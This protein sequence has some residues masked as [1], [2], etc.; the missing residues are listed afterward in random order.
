MNSGFLSRTA[1]LFL[2]FVFFAGADPAA[3]DS[4]N[5]RI[6]RLS[7]VQGDV[8]FSRATSG[9]P[10]ADQN[11]AWETAELNLPIRQ[12]YVLATGN[13]RAEVEFENGSMAFLNESTVLEFYDLTLENGGRNTRLVLRQGTASFHVNPGNEDYFSVTGGDFTAVAGP[14]SSFRMDNSDG[15]STVD[16]TKGRINVIHGKTTTPLVKGQSLSMQAGNDAID[17]GRLPSDDDFDHWVSGRVDSVV[18]ATNAALQYTSSPYYTSGFAD[19]YTYGSWYPISG[20]GNC[21]R[22]YGAGFG[23]SPFDSGGWF[24]DP[25]YGT[26]FIGSQP[27]GWL[28]YHF[29]GWIFDPLYGW[30]W[31]PG[32]FGYG[33]FVNWSPVTAR[34]VRSKTGLLGVVP[35]HPLDTKSKAPVNLAQGVMPI[36]GGVTSARVPVQVADGWKV[37]KNPPR[38]AFGNEPVRVGAPPLRT[39]RTFVATNTSERAGAVSTGSSSTIAYDPREHRFVNSNPAPTELAKES[40]ARNENSQPGKDIAKEHGVNPEQ[41]GTA[42]VATVHAGTTPPPASTTARASV[43]PTRVVTPPPA[44]RTSSGA[45]AENSGGESSRGASTSHASSAPASHPS[46]GGGRPH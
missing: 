13:G 17:V 8:R 38:E 30:L 35:V 3:A 19:L 46:S 4:S 25:F 5:A 29:G 31:A 6:I 45:R 24:S 42:T 26:G 37:V 7:L 9:Q 20:F 27:W 28:P 22:P 44:P 32:G 2:S 11:T 14:R 23:W 33:G 16:I 1:L 15:G 40:E 43:P 21:W 18:T 12:G 36:K 39:T 41:K 10:V 34:F